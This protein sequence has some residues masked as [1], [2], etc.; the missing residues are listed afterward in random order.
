MAQVDSRRVLFIYRQE[1]YM[2]AS[3]EAVH[4]PQVRLEGVEGL[5]HRDA[6]DRGTEGR[7]RPPLPAPHIGVER[8]DLRR[9]PREV[10][11]DAAPPRGPPPPS[12]PRQIFSVQNGTIGARSRRRSWRTAW[13]VYT[14]PSSPSYAR[15]F[16]IST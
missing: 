15:P 13:S 1:A 3:R 11:P 6:L 12:P 9:E 2:R 14:A 10:S 4:P 7:A 5:G 16:T 8:L